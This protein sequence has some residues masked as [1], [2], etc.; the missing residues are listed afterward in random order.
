MKT[1]VI[2]K[3]NDYEL[4]DSGDGYKLERFGKYIVSRPDPNVIWEKKNPSIWNTA[5]AIFN[6]NK[7]D[8][9][10]WDNKNVKSD[11][12]FEFE[13]VKMILKLTP[14]KHV[15]IFPEQTENW[16]WFGALLTQNSKHATHNNPNILNLFGYT[17]GAT[18]YAASCGA[19]VTH[20]DASKPSVMWA[21][22]N[23]RLSGLDNTP[24]RW[25][26][27]DAK[28]FVARE[29]KRGIKYD[30]VIMDPPA[31]GRDP[32]GKIFKF[33]KDVPEILNLISKTLNPKPLFFLINSYSLGYSP[34]VIKNM[35]G[36]ILPLEKI[37]CGELQISEK[38]GE[39][40]LPCGVFARY[41]N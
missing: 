7:V 21:R 15:G 35:L 5:D 31:F 14:F 6:V 33:E 32:K 3:L 2:D 19:K 16:K 17:G 24:I 25:I 23:Q 1:I 36:N 10:R 9:S 37:E 11:W 20:V 12:M 4:L 8:S 30:A 39:R 22:E 40:N 27:D 13:K 38:S 18:L 28:K 29:V 34:T 26:V 41:E